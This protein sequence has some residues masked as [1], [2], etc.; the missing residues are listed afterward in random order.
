[1]GWGDQKYGVMSGK[2]CVGGFSVK[3]FIFCLHNDTAKEDECPLF[4]VRGVP[5]CV[6]DVL[7]RGYMRRSN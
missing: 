3:I 1:M 7:Y 4:Q 2:T 5:S 6:Q